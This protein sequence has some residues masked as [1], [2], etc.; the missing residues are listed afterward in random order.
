MSIAAV[1]TFLGGIGLFLLGM[2]LM[3]EGLTT[4]TGD[5]LRNSLATATRSRGRALASGVLITT[6]VQSSSAVIFT[7]VGFVNAGLLSLTQSVGVVYGANLGTTLTSWVV[8]LLGFNVDLQAMSLPFVGI[9]MFMSVIYRSGRYGAIGQALAGFGLFFLG[10]DVLKG[11]FDTLGQTVSLE[12]FA[13][14]GIQS[15]LLFVLIGTIMTLFMQSS[16]AAMTVTLTATAGGLIPLEAAAAIAIGA[17]MGTTSTGLFASIGATAPA[18]RA[19][20]IHVLFSVVT[21]IVCFLLLSPL[22]W[23][24]KAIADLIGSQDQ[25][26][27]MLA[28]F[29][30][31]MKLMGL[32]IMWPLTDTLVTWLEKFI[33]SEEEN[34]A[35]PQF[36]DR[37]VQTSVSLAMNALELELHRM[38][39][40]ARRLAREAISAEEV[41]SRQ[42]AGGHRALE[43]LNVA[44]GEFASGIPRQG[45]PSAIL[46]SLPDAQR[47][48]Q[49]LVNVAEHALE[50]AVEHPSTQIAHPALSQ[51]RDQLLAH[52]VAL[53]DAATVDSPDWSADALA[54]Q[55][56]EFESGYQAFKRQLLHAG[57]AG[58]LAPKR[59][60]ESLERFSE[61]HRIV[62]QAAKAAIYL[63]RFMAQNG[64]VSVSLDDALHV[65]APSLESDQESNPETPPV[66]ESELRIEPEQAPR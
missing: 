32:A 31:L 47:V 14:H 8:A 37:S 12:D 58:D 22:M 29:H 30:T 57:T 44:L 62:D 41:N 36:L 9:G 27:L 34:D 33:K 40:M 21:A 59:M 53:L 48:G 1:L 42:L 4:A 20:F 38:S 16:T 23:L 43:S 18:K 66:S 2:R 55:R 5:A 26:A 46:N 64:V 65:Q 19:A 13:A 54:E 3:T 15:L 28:I 60:A 63:D 10:V 50:M 39:R 49:Y 6:L 11:A 25:P 7:T 61:L 35:R 56:R 52:A 45:V 51:A 17:N 24:V